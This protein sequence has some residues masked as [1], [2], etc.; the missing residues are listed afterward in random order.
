MYI[1]MYTYRYKYVYIYICP[2]HV[3]QYMTYLQQLANDVNMPY[4]NITLDVHTN[5]C[6][7]TLYHSQML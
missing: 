1:Y 3:Y 7:T 2:I 5:F 4:V 6:G